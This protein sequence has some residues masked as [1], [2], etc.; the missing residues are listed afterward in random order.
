[1]SISPKNNTIMVHPMTGIL[2]SLEECSSSPSQKIPNKEVA[3][4]KEQEAP[5]PTINPAMIENFF[6]KLKLE[7]EEAKGR[8]QVQKKSIDFSSIKALRPTEEQQVILSQIKRIYL[9]I[10]ESLILKTIQYE[11]AHEKDLTGLKK[12]SKSLDAP[13]ALTY[14]EPGH[15]LIHTK[16]NNGSPYKEIKGGFKVCYGVLEVNGQNVKKRAE[17]F[18][19]D[20]NTFENRFP[21]YKTEFSSSHVMKASLYE[22]DH[23]KNKKSLIYPFYHTDLSTY[24]NNNEV[25]EEQTLSL[26]TQYVDGVADI[27]EKGFM[28]RDLKEKNGLLKLNEKGEVLKVKVSDLDSVEQ[29][30]N[31]SPKWFGTL[32]YVP[33]AVLLRE[34]IQGYKSDVYALGV[35]ASHIFDTTGELNDENEPLNPFQLRMASVVEQL[36]SPNAQN[37]PTAKELSLELKQ[38]H[39]ELF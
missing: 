37:R 32:S 26:F 21:N 11:N 20:R 7:K 12:I 2:P 1:M 19:R 28:H 31:A 35:I 29:E 24:L 22:V 8:N 34:E 14:I 13:F 9:L 3:K 25:S 18:I 6:R 23:G 33:G 5:K 30:K 39:R 16:K 10:D 38:I 17:L 27:H 15:C 4:E 36:K